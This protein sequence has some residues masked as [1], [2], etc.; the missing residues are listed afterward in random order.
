[1]IIY[2]ILHKKHYLYF[3]KSQAYKLSKVVL[4]QSRNRICWNPSTNM[5]LRHSQSPQLSET[6]CTRRA[7]HSWNPV[8][9]RR[10][11]T[12]QK[13][14]KKVRWIIKTYGSSHEAITLIVQ[15]FPV[16]QS[17]IRLVSFPVEFSV[18][19]CLR[20]FS[21]SSLLH[22]DRHIP[23]EKSYKYL[24]KRPALLPRCWDT[25]QTAF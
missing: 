8:R 22:T 18:L 14:K 6:A 15:I 1:M 5:Q 20:F 19:V 21:F 23:R 9:E 7:Q 3:S 4:S 16:Y 10:L 2:I 12:P 13:K 11:S 17:E 24:S 25:L